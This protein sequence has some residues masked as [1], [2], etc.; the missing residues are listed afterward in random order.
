[1]FDMHREA[2]AKRPGVLTKVGMDT[3]VDPRR[4]GCAMNGSGH[5]EPMVKHVEFAGEEW[6]FFPSIIPQRRHHSRHHGRRA[7]QSLLRA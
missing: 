3:F 1:M 2:A 4:E 6:L 7:R 5:C